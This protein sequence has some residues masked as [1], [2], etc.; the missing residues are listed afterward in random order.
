[1]VFSGG[2]VDITIHQV[3]DKNTLKEID[4]ASGGAWGGT[5]V[6]EAF[7]QFLIKLVGVLKLAY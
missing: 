4:S 3:V 2:T 5:M 7:K 1:M 6:D